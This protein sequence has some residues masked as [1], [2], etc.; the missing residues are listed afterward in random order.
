MKNLLLLS[1][2]GII[3]GCAPPL[4]NECFSGLMDQ[5][6]SAVLIERDEETFKFISV[7]NSEGVL[8]EQYYPNTA[9][10]KTLF[11]SYSWSKCT[12]Y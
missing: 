11:E 5:W 4:E 8:D 7:E 1:S 3:I 2:V 9:E 12:N 10:G 6:E